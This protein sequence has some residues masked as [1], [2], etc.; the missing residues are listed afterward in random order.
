MVALENP[1]EVMMYDQ[2]P[3]LGTTRRELATNARSLDTTFKTVLSGQRNQRRRNTRITVLMTQ[4]RRRNLQS[5]H[6]QNPQSIHLTRRAAQ[7][8]LEH[9]LARKWTLKLNLKKMRK[10]RHLRTQTLVWRA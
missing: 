10:M 4:R 5:P 1:Q 9:S 8:K 3:H 7:R 6:H 2:I